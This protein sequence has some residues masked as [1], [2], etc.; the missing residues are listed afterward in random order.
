MRTRFARIK[1]FLAVMAAAASIGNRV[2]ATDTP[3]APLLKVG[4]AERDITPELGMEAPGGYAKA[5]HTVFHDACKVRASVFDD[6][7]AR[8]ALVGVDALEI[9]PSTV[10]AARKAIQHR[11]GIPPQ[12]VLVGASH[13]HTSGPT[14][15]VAPGEFDH[16]SPLVRSLAYEKTTCADPKYL[17]HVEQQIANAVCAANDGRA[18]SLCGA[19]N[20]FE[21]K[22]A[23]NRRFR[24]K[25]G[26]C[27]THPGQG[28]PDIVEP[29]GP[30]D[31]NVGV[32]GVWNKDGK[33]TGCVVNFGCH[34]TT[35]P[36]GISANWI[37][38][39]ERT[40]RGAMGQDVV[41]VFLQGASG[42]VTQ[43]DNRSPYAHV[44]QERWG[45]IVGGRV[46]AEAVKVLVGMDRGSLAPVNARSETMPIKR[47]VPRPDR[48]QKSLELVQQPEAKVGHTEWAF[49]KEIVLLDASLAKEKT[50]DVEVQAIQVGP[51]IVLANPA[52]IFCQT[53]LDMRAKSAFPVTFVVELA[54]GRLGYVPT[55]EALGPH[56]GGY[57]TR[58][59]SCANLEP[60]AERQIVEG[61]LRLAGQLTP[62]KLPV[63]PKAAPF[64]G[65]WT[66][67]NVPP[68]LD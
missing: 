20:G 61:C 50:K 40:I 15:G 65:A 68:E 29:A 38:H 45:E 36:N 54:N 64:G 32:I 3:S 2:E 27:Y 43:V 51:V 11:C 12:A 5:R 57:E 14:C 49:A 18:E 52:E 7:R 67:G 42:D 37:Y 33:C 46:G 48:V 60:T 10:A 59:T 13:S 39:M 6:G 44:G 35:G 9:L 66:Y 22:A 62:G 16:A 53:G 30:I 63:R 28:N 24:M 34:G 26:L 31:P 25:N 58:L 17:K 55:L 47:R 1:G 4:F 19:G 21:D 23:F 8:V 41:V 56:G